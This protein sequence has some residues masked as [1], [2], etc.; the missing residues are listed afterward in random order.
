MEDSILIV[1]DDPNVI[2]AISRSLMEEPYSIYAA[3]SGVEGLNILKGHKIKLVISDEMMPGM[4]GTEFLSAVKNIF[5]ETIR[6]MLTGHA[7]IQAAMKAV[8]SGEIYRFFSKPWDDIE[9]KLSIRSAIEK[10]NL[11]EEN[12]SLLKTVKRQA[13][14]LKQ[15]EKMHPGITSL[16]KDT[17]GHFILP[18]I[19]DTDEDISEIIAQSKIKKDSA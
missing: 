8:N 13:S 4:S 2:S 14:E 19:S 1:D 16:K 11:E 15:L 9:L 18:E 6:I 10:Y 5:P 17:E 3:N 12:R 7:S